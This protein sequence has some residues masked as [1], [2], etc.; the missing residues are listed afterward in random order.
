VSLRLHAVT[1]VCERFPQCLV[2]RPVPTRRQ[3]QI[4]SDLG[5]LST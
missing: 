2:F 5:G 4:H 3:K 1:K